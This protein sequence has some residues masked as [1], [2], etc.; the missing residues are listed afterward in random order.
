MLFYTAFLPVASSNGCLLKPFLRGH[1]RALLACR[2]LRL[3]SS[4]GRIDFKAGARLD[5]VGCSCG[6]DQLLDEVA[7]TFVQSSQLAKRKL[8]ELVPSIALVSKSIFNIA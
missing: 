3:S 6:I 8:V 2:S 4:E 7:F 1:D 5:N